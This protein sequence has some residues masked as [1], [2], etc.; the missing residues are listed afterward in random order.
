MACLMQLPS[1]HLICTDTHTHTHLSGRAHQ[2][3]TQLMAMEDRV[4][5]AEDAADGVVDAAE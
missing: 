4:D 2:S 1:I 3:V 5:A